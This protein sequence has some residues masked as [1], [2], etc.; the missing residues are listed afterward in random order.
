MVIKSEPQVEAVPQR[1]LVQSADSTTMT[2]PAASLAA[3]S[4]AHVST[5]HQQQQRTED[6]R[7]RRTKHAALTAAKNT[8]AEFKRLQTIVPSIRRKDHVS[9][10]D[11]I[12]EAIKYIDDLQDQLFDRLGDEDKDAKVSEDAENAETSLT[13]PSALFEVARRGAGDDRLLGLMDR[14]LQGEGVGD[15]DLDSEED[16]EMDDE[17]LDEEESD[18]GIVDC[19]QSSAASS[20]DSSTTSN[21]DE[22]EIVLEDDLKKAADDE[23]EVSGGEISSEM[24]S[25]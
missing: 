3:R 5:Q 9:K 20:A 8:K 15:L 22:D 1:L 14:V 18:E 23:Q 12:L 17:D 24:R 19:C 21:L 25:K 13:S 11:I 16:E 4:A 10:L 6:Q 2:S 7:L